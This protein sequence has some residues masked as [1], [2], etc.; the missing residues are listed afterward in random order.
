ME[1]PGNGLLT[2]ILGKTVRMNS[3]QKS[4]ST[5]F[6]FDHPRQV[7]D[8]GKLIYYIKERGIRQCAHLIFSTCKLVFCN[9]SFAAG[10]RMVQKPPYW[11]AKN[12][13]WDIEN[14][15]KLN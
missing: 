14:K 1:A 9:G 10:D 15:E 7:R 13:H 2:D 3:F 11:I 6:N 5:F 4:L 8:W 12:E